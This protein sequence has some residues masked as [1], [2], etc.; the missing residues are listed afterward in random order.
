MAFKHAVVRVN[1][2]TCVAEEN[3]V[4]NITTRLKKAFSQENIFSSR[5]FTKRLYGKSKTLFGGNR[6]KAEKKKFTL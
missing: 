4:W 1:K 2:G 3:D 6:L 5:N